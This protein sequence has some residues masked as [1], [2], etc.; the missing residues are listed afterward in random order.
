LSDEREIPASTFLTMNDTKTLAAELRRY[1]AWRRGYQ[2]AKQPNPSEIGVMLDDAADCLDEMEREL[3]ESRQWS[4]TLAD[5]ADDTRADLAAEQDIRE[6]VE[7]VNAALYEQ[8]EAERAL[9]DRLAGAI[10][11]VASEFGREGDL[12]KALA[13]W[14]EARR[15]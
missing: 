13:A 12:H 10:E 11:Q 8:L 9:A 1:N 6:A 7:S 5:V 2:T 14:K 4:S 3:A 15:E